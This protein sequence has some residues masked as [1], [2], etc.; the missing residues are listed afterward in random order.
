MVCMYFPGWLVGTMRL[1]AYTVCVALL[2]F[3]IILLGMRREIMNNWGLYRCNPLILPFAALFGH[4]PS[5]TFT[6]CLSSNIDE[7]TGP[8]VKP[9]DDL[10]SML[11]DTTNSMTESLGDVG[12]V[13]SNMRD[14]VTD[15][16]ANVATKMGNVGA[17]A[18]FMMYKIQA[19]FQKLLA[20]Y[21]T[22]LYFAWSMMK[23]L[24]SMIRDPVL[25]ETQGV[26]DKAV[27]IVDD[28][29]AFVNDVGKALNKSIDNTSS[30]AKKNV[31]NTNSR[32]QR[33]STILTVEHKRILKTHQVVR[34][35]TKK[36]KKSLSNLVLIHE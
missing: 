10:F 28:P 4:D 12:T 20:L 9:Y 23:G 36:L 17:T 21:V 11:K 8:V 1:V 31:D 15:G 27:K 29:G 19:I 7:A 18:Q 30:R 32:A 26:L 24:E 34:K 2:T 33:M 5:Q 13:L 25:V 22:L 14:D 3:L 16:I 6:E 35:N